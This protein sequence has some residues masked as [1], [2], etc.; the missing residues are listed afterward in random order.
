MGQG[1]VNFSRV[2]N[3]R[4]D[5]KNLH[6]SNT[7]S[8]NTENNNDTNRYEKPTKTPLSEISEK[9]AIK[10]GIFHFFTERTIDLLSFF[11][12]RCKKND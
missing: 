11:W 7:Y 6:T 12:N 8:S 1:R 2:E 3:T 4:L 9:E 5:V 10:M